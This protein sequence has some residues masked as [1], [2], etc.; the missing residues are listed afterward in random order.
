MAIRQLTAADIP[1]MRQLAMAF[2]T[3]HSEALDIPLTELQQRPPGYFQEFLSMVDAVYGYED[4]QSQLRGWMAF[5]ADGDTLVI[6][7]GAYDP[8]VSARN[9][10][11]AL[12]ALAKQ[13][14]DAAVARGFTHLRG[15]VQKAYTAGVNYWSGFG[16]VDAGL[17][18]TVQT[19]N[20]EAW[21]AT[22][23]LARYSQGVV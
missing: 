3:A 19:A 15:R 2:F 14:R 11:A 23:P 10:K 13:M 4:A 12:D 5:A 6:V 20:G 17:V 18:T 7:V 22:V 9:L 16:L 8:T 1:A 21:E